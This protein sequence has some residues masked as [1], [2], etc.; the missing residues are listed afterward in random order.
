MKIKT[1]ALSRLRND[2]HFEFFDFLVALVREITPAALKI[3][4]PYNAVVTLHRD[5]DTAL[6]KI[7]KSP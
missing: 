2:E 1:L 6:K 5:E 3:T 4:E 7:T